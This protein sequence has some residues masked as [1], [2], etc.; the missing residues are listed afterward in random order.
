MFCVVL[1]H[2]IGE[3]F[4]SLTDYTSAWW[5]KLVAVESLIRWCIPVFI[6]IS[7]TLFLNPKREVTIR[8]IWRK[9][10]KHLFVAFCLWSFIYSII[11]CCS[12]SSGLDVIHRIL[13]FFIIMFLKPYEHLWY[14]Y[15]II[16]L[17][18]LTPLIKKITDNSTK[19]DLQYWLILMAFF[20]VIIPF[21]RK[22]KIVDFYFSS[23]IGYLKLDFLCGYTF[24]YVLGYY[25]FAYFDKRY[26]TIAYGIGVVGV[27]STFFGTILLSH[28]FNKVYTLF[29]YMMPNTAAISVAVFIFF[30]RRSGHL[31][32]NSVAL[33]SR[34]KK[35]ADNSF[36]I[37]LSHELLVFVIKKA[38]LTIANV[39]SII[40]AFIEALFIIALSYM[41][42]CILGKNSFFRK[43]MM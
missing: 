15:M 22:V 3:H 32:G 20:G 5:I 10:I 41:A 18:I 12:N 11:I 26:E 9:Y 36:G 35:I 16:G 8:I 21:L 34:L 40:F 2:V 38:G 31:F 17:Y 19:M 37:Y 33:K 23:V 25:L 6:M 1:I 4:F 14:I 39:H 30:I 13:E 7:G 42:I 29:D 28:M 24:Y 27:L 43:Y